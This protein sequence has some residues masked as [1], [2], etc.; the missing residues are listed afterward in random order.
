MNNKSV[1]SAI[2]KGYFDIP[3][4]KD[5]CS[6]I[7]I[8][9]SDIKTYDDFLHIPFTVKE[10]L[11]N[12]SPYERTLTARNEIY[13]LYSS[14]GT[15]GNKTFYIYNHID[16]KKQANFVRTYFKTIGMKEGGLGATFAPIGSAVMGHCMM[17]QFQAMCMGMTICADLSPESVIET[18][19]KLPVTDI[20]TLPRV[21]SSIYEKKEWRDIAKKSTVERLVLGGDFLSNARRRIIE[22]TWNAKAYDSFGMSEAFGP[23]ANECTEQN[24]LHY[25]DDSLFIEIIDPETL[26]PISGDEI[27]VGVYTTL[28]EKGFPLL[29]YWSG[30]LFRKISTPCPCGSKLPRIEYF[31]RACDCVS[32]NN[33]YISPKQVEEITL[34]VNIKNCQVRLYDKKIVLTYDELGVIPDKNTIEMLSELFTGLEI[35]T[36]PVSREKLDL[37]RLKPKLIVD[38]R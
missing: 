3:F 12:T 38:C 11:R 29:R 24:G 7:G 19:S 2:N 15:T 10:D 31:G 36:V 32:I 17:W 6:E 23:L 27:G 34:T 20:A 9:L 4:Y 8:Q 18:I 1:I 35:K 21:A 33:T 13:G 25:L 26:M 30:D 22:D 37:N 5:K 28:W 14:S 16:R